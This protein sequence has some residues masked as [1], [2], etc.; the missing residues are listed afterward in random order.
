MLWQEYQRT[1]DRRP[2]DELVAMYTPLVRYLAYAKIKELPARYEIDDLVSCGLEALIVSI[3]RYDPEKGAS[4]EQFA[5]TRIHGA[6][7]D[8]LRRHDWAPRSVRRWERDIRRARDR[9]S[10]RHGR[11]PSREE[12]AECLAI[13]VPELRR[14]QHD[15]E[16]SDVGSLNAQVV[17]DGHS[18]VERI[19]TIASDDRT[20]DPA[21]A[22]ELTDT[23]DRFRAAFQTLPARDR[24]VA[25]L[26][27]VKDLKL[28]EVG[29]I[30]GV[31]ES[32]VSQIHTGIK[33]RL[34][35]M[36]QTDGEPV[37]ELD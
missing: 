18:E 15:I 30:L 28:R 2:R 37:A 4:L 33:A 23:K 24:E 21:R 7:I 27:Y 6:I 34:R 9:F 3:D 31:S 35:R 13:D 8:E 19:E 20:A 12:L 5:W 32:R 22:A 26:L 25:V 29:D 14:R 11:P 16:V 10:T 17:L 1:H 36:L